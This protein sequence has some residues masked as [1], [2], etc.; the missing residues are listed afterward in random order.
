MGMKSREKICKE[1]GKSEKEYKNL[2]RKKLQL[3]LF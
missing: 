1:Q 2:H 3:E